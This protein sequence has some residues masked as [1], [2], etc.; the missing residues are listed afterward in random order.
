MLCEYFDHKTVHDLLA[1]LHGQRFE[2][3]Y[4]FKQ[5]LNYLIRMGYISN[6]FQIHR[7]KTIIDDSI[8][9][10]TRLL[11]HN[12]DIGSLAT[13]LDYSLTTGNIQL[14]KKLIQ[15][16]R[17]MNIV[18]SSEEHQKLEA[19]LNKRRDPSLRAMFEMLTFP[20]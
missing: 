1:I 15:V 6:Q 18:P 14:M 11:Q 5:S 3:N 7:L 10:K 9:A 2:R 19:V 17:I 20:D 13:A 16:G 4:F 8:F 12:R